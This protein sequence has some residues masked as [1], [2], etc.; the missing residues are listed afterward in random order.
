MALNP[1][2]CNCL[3]PLHFK[4]LMTVRKWRPWHSNSR[5]ETYVFYIY[6]VSQKSPPF[7]FF[8]TQCT[9]HHNTASVRQT[10]CFIFV[11][12]LLIFNYL[13][14]NV[15][16]SFWVYRYFV[17]FVSNVCISYLFPF[18]LN[19]LV[20]WKKTVTD[21]D[22]YI[23]SIWQKSFPKLSAASGFGYCRNPKCSQIIICAFQ[24]KQ[25]FRSCIRR[26]N[27]ELNQSWFAVKPLMLVCPLFREPNKTAKLKAANINCRPK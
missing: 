27:T 21:V 14:L 18:S 22:R 1:F 17:H 5:L 16:L 6:T 13:F 7:Y 12:L 26:C 11:I 8:G 9:S 24:S 15:I 4:G 20:A 19:G 10:A 3:T 25:R 2:K 23:F